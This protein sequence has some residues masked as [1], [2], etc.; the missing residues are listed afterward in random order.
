MYRDE[1]SH[2]TRSIT[3]V[4]NIHAGSPLSPAEY[5]RGMDDGSDGDGVIHRNLEGNE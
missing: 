4:L 5:Q 2:V 3:M 1:F